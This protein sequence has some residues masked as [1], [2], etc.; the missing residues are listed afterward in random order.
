MKRWVDLMAQHGG[1]PIV[2]YGSIFF[3]WLRGKIIMVEDYSYARTDFHDDPDLALPK[4]SQWRD[5]GKN[6]FFIIDCFWH[7]N[8][9][10]YYVMYLRI[11]K[12]S[13]YADVTPFRPRGSSQI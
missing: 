1:L 8:Y 2:T 9:E 6:D 13:Q 11:I 5:I 12:S 4:G 10:I 7:F 3:E